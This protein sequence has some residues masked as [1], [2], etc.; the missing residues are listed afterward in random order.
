M[1][2][3]HLSSYFTLNRRYSRSANL[4]RD[5]TN[6]ESLSGYVIT[7]RAEQSLR[8]IMEGFAGMHTARS[9]MLT[10]VY[11]T[12]KSAFAQFLSSLCA[13]RGKE[14]R[15]RA[16]EIFKGGVEK[17]LAKLAESAI[18]D[19]GFIRAVVTAQREPISHT[20]TRALSGGVSFFW[21]SNSETGF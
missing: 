20:I 5:L 11:G 21:K 14:V 6:P 15:A 7:E 10:G 4:E 2:S 18:P 16:E 13:P 8:R 9:W 19:R 3:Q 1:S 12:G 17:S